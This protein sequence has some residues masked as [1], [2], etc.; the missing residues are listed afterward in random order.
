MDKAEARMD[1][2]DKQLKATANL[3]RV[4]MKIAVKNSKDIASLIASHRRLEK[5]MD[6]L[7]DLL[8]AG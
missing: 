6:R 8:V 5:K 2:F 7:I 1:R 3:V 4:G